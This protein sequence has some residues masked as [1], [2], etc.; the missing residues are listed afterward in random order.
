M[1]PGRRFM[2]SRCYAM[3]R[4]ESYQ[5]FHLTIGVIRLL[6]AERQV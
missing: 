4:R 3:I 2:R 1:R 5:P 6:N